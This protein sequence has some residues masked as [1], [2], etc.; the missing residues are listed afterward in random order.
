M[1]TPRALYP[2]QYRFDIV[3]W[4]SVGNHDD[5]DGLCGIRILLIMA[6]VGAQNAVQ[7]LAGGCSAVRSYCLENLDYGP[8]DVT[9]WCMGLCGWLRKVIAAANPVAVANLWRNY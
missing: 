7:A 6:E 1:E 3:L 2:R 8:G 9:L 4:F 5:V